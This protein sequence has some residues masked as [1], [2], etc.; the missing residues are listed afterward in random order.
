[1]ISWYFSFDIFKNAEYGEYFI[2][3]VKHMMDE[4][5]KMVEVGYICETRI[6]GYSKS[7]FI[8]MFFNYLIVC[9]NLRNEKN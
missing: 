6:H 9:I 5:I 1:M 4:K 2:F 8:K 7:K 3:L